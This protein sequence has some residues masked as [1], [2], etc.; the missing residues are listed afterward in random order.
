LNVSAAFLPVN[1]ET[2]EVSDQ[3]KTQNLI[4]ELTVTEFEQLT[5]KKMS[6]LQ[7][8]QYKKVQKKLQKNGRAYIFPERDE[9]TEGFQAL[10]FFGTI[11]TFGLLAFIMLFTAKDRNAIRWAGYGISVLAIAVSVITIISSLSG[12]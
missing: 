8:W 5:G 10:P 1:S 6:G 7:K 9:L 4:R 3:Q 2:K 12:Y 11:L